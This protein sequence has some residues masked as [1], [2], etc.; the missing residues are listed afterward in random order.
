[1]FFRTLEYSYLKTILWLF[2]LP[3]LSKLLHRHYGDPQA[4]TRYCDKYLIF[5]TGDK[6]SGRHNQKLYRF[7]TSWFHLE[8]P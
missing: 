5:K 8:K 7:V 6:E 4:N 1:M 3:C 2:L